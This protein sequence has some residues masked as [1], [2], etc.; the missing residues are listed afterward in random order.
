MYDTALSLGKQFYWSKC[1]IF[2]LGTH[3]STNIDECISTPC[4][5]G[6]RCLDGV[7][8]YVCDCAPGY[9]QRHCGVNTDECASDPCQNGATCN[10]QVNGYNCSCAP[11]YAGKSS[12]K[13]LIVHKFDI[14]HAM[15]KSMVTTVHVL[16]DM[17]VSP[18]GSF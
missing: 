3:C 18:A 4:Q 2:F 15:T 9:E 17:L 8:G 1:N 7:N 6:G 14:E 11:G 5:N 10:D 12:W 13:F 16:Q